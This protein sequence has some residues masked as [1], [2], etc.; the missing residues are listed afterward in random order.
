MGIQEYL[1]EERIKT[2]RGSFRIAD[3]SKERMQELGY[4]YY[5][6]TEDGKFTIMGNGKR[7]FAIRKGEELR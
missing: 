6:D 2:P 4:G 7:A 5:F 3:I 1:R